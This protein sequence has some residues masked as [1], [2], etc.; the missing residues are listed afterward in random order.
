SSGI[1]QTAD[2]INATPGAQTY[3]NNK[4]EDPVFDSN[5]Q[6]QSGS[7]CINTGHPYAQY[8][9]PNKEGDDKRADIGYT[10]GPGAGGSLGFDSPTSAALGGA[11]AKI[12]KENFD[13]AIRQF[14]VDKQNASGELKQ[15]GNCFGFVIYIYTGS[16]GPSNLPTGVSR[17]FFFNYLGVDNVN[18]KPLTEPNFKKSTD[19]WYENIERD[20][21]SSKFKRGRLVLFRDRRENRNPNWWECGHAAVATGLIPD[22]DRPYGYWYRWHH[23]A[24]TPSNKAVDEILHRGL[25]P[26]NDYRTNQVMPCRN[27]IYN[28]LKTVNPDTGKI[29]QGGYTYTWITILEPQFDFQPDFPSPY[30]R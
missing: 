4:V 21:T 12:T 14:T 30:A 9:E 3:G 28:L 13:K 24:G 20:G 1:A 15:M 26:A 5:Y 18:N 8:E 17:D 6:L 11:R 29:F 19:D 27:S 7:P 22:V 16:W 2:Q 23:Y 10:G 25:P